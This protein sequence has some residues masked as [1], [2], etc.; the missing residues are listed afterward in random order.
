MATAKDLILTR[1]NAANDG[2]EDILVADVAS[3]IFMLDSSSNPTLVT[4][5]PG[6]VLA[7]G[8]LCH[9]WQI[10]V[11]LGD[12][13][14]TITTGLKLTFRMDAKVVLTEVRSSVVTVSSSGV[15]TMDLKESG[16]TVLSTLPSIDASEKTSLTGTPAVISD[17]NLADD[18][19]MT[20]EVTAAGTGAKGAKMILIGYIVP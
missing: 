11:A 1:W 3:S 19:E 4:L 16:T 17:A 12:E 5:G 6:F 10:T 8:V 7:S 20:A 13:T 18:A 9:R 14:T 15:V 2:K